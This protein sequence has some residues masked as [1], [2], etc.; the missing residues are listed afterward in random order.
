MAGHKAASCWSIQ[1]KRQHNSISRRAAP[2]ACRTAANS[3][4]IERQP[5]ALPLGETVFESPRLAAPVAQFDHSLER[6]QAIR[7][8]AVSDNF[9][10]SGNLVQSFLELGHWHIDRAANVSGRVFLGR[11]H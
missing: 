8:A 11:P 1:S 9:L 6:H 3:R 2:W 4:P 5:G 7:A 10:A